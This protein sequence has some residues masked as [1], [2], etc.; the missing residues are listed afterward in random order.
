M[1][2]TTFPLG[3]NDA[4]E[5]D[6]TVDDYALQRYRIAVHLADPFVEAA[7]LRLAFVDLILV[8]N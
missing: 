6:V 1:V 8:D 5:A 3:G 2:E 7:R 4:T